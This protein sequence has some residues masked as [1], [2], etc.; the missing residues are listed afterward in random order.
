M[1]NLAIWHAKW[2]DLSCICQGLWGKGYEE[3]DPSTLGYMAKVQNSAV[4]SDLMKVDFY[5]NLRL[6]RT[7][8]Q[9]HMLACWEYVS[10]CAQMI[11]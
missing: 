5:Q 3:S 8:L 10:I 6:I 2:T 4:P 11:N 9:G 7:T 1:T